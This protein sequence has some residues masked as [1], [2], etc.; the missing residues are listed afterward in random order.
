MSKGAD[1]HVRVP[2]V[3]VLVAL[4]WQHC[5]TPC[6]GSTG[7]RAAAE[8]P[9]N[10]GKRHGGAHRH[11]TFSDRTPPRPLSHTWPRN[12]GLN[13]SM[14]AMV[15]STVGSSG[16]SE[17]EGRRVWPLDSKNDRNASRISAPVW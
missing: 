4:E 15:S 11:H 14:P 8:L 10:D 9:L 2:L 1:L 5:W 16:T 17:E 7:K 12:T 3:A 13:C 6:H